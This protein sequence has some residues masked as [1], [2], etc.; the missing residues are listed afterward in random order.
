MK[1]IMALMMAFMMVVVSGCVLFEKKYNEASFEKIYLAAAKKTKEAKKW[2]VHLEYKAE[3]GKMEVFQGYYEDKEGNKIA[4][5]QSACNDE[6]ANFSSY[7][8]GAEETKWT[9]FNSVKKDGKIIRDLPNG[10]EEDAKM[11][12][13]FNLSNIIDD[14]FELDLSKFEPEA[15]EDIAEAG[16]ED[17][18]E[19]LE[20]KENTGIVDE[21]YRRTNLNTYQWI[22]A[23]EGNVSEQGKADYK[24]AVD[25]E[26]N[27][28]DDKI[29]SIKMYRGDIHYSY[30]EVKTIQ[31][32]Y[33]FDVNKYYEMF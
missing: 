25:R 28:K 29:R 17:I 21:S 16:I 6:E 1:K 12:V 2:M 10:F 13:G 18:F 24:T 8:K 31:I 14:Y 3:C 26:I 19:N 22:S 11:E 33:S 27:I 30:E 15:V 20:F 32:K 7:Y 5:L 23:L 4:F 9:V